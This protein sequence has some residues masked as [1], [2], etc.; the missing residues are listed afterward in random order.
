VWWKQRYSDTIDGTVVDVI[1]A[2]AL[3]LRLDDGRDVTTRPLQQAQIRQLAAVLADR[4]DDLGPLRVEV[5]IG[6]GRHGQVEYVRVRPD[7]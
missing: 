6:V 4:P 7:E 2:S 5:R 1:G 3:R